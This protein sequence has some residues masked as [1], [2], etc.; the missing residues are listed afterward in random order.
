[1]SG[2]LWPGMIGNAMVFVGRLLWGRLVADGGGCVRAACTVQFAVVKKRRA[3]RG[4]GRSLVRAIDVARPM[5]GLLTGCERRSD[6]CDRVAQQD[7]KLIQRV[8]LVQDAV[9]PAQAASQKVAAR[10]RR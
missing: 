9:C 2:P 4:S 3:H 7:F 5:A 8:G 10:R 1:M 6:L